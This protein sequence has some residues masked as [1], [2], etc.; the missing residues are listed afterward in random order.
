MGK[1][2]VFFISVLLILSLNS[3]PQDI[4]FPDCE[5]GDAVFRDLWIKT[6]FFHIPIKNVGHAAIYLNSDS[7]FKNKDK[8]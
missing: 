8:K 2:A 3:F 1:K 7:R 6:K 4:P 5:K